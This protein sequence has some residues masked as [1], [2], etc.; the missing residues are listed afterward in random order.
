MR[1]FGSKLAVAL[2]LAGPLSHAGVPSTTSRSGGGEFVVNRSVPCLSDDQRRTIQAD[3]AQ[4]VAR[5]EAEGRLA[6]VAPEVVAFR[7]PVAGLGRDFGVHGVSNFVDHNVAYPDF[8]RDYNCGDRTY[9]LSNGYNHAGVDIFTWPFAWRKMDDSDVVI[10]AAAAGTIVSRADGNFDRSCGFNS[11]PWNGVAIRHSDGSTAWY[12]HMKKG[13]VTTKGIGAAVQAGEYLGVIGSSGSSTGPHLHFEVYANGGALIDPYQGACNGLNNTSWWSSQRPY[14]DSAIN[15]LATHS[16]PPD[17]GT[18][19]N[20]ETPNI[21]DVFPPG[22]TL[23]SAA[24]YRDQLAGQTTQ[25]TIRRPNATVWQSWSGAL[26]SGTCVACWWYSTW[27]LPATAEEG[28]WRY[29]AVYQGTTYEVPFMVQT[30]GDFNA[31]GQVDLLF[32]HSLS[33]RVVAWLMDGVSRTVGVFVTPDPA[34]TLEL[35]GSDDFNGDRRTD[36]VYWDRTTGAVQFWMMNGTTRVGAPVA[37][38]GAASLGLNWRLAATGDFN[39]DAK[40]DLLWLDYNSASVVIWA[41]NGTTRTGV[42]LPSPSAAG[43]LN[44]RVVAALDFDND[45]N[46]DLLWYN[47]TSGKIVIWTMNASAVRIGGG[48][49]NPPQAGDANWRVVAGGNFGIGP[50]GVAATNDLVWRNDTSGRLV[51]WHLDNAGNRT[52]GRFTT[53][54]SPG[55][56][57][58]WRVAGPR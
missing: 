6:P 12:G 37:L 49:T 32:Q 23:Y 19:P 33:N 39:H 9:D 31:D 16:A 46:R 4:N 11:N 51:I 28:V 58:N 20:P 38:G 44:W 8:L 22:A 17:F 14:W 13:S 41:M 18:C 53:P 42:I 43:D 57:T 35:V 29:R 54:D 56:A 26:S 47:V 27:T 7:W 24:Y 30:K 36:L 1:Q 25:Y 10:L 15:A 50:R 2:L 48:F 52:S 5:L 55:D 21:R 3:I 40:P 34:S 45:G